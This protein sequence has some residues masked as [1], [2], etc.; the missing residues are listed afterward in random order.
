VIVQYTSYHN[1]MPSYPRQIV[2]QEPLCSF[3]DHCEVYCSAACCG[4]EAFEVHPAL[5]LRKVIDMNLAGADGATAFSMA[6]HQMAGLR[7]YVA[8]ERIQTVDGEAPFWRSVENEL[9]E[10]WLSMEQ[11]VPWL[12]KWEAAFCEAS[13]YGGLSGADRACAK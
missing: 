5:L 7:Q 4:V 11:L 1:R 10:F 3:M 6:R 12:V 9:P 8:S 2:I 13:H